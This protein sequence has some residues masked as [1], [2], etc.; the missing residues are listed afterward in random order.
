MRSQDK[1]LLS[2]RRDGGGG[3]AGYREPQGFRAAIC[4]G[5]Y[6]GRKT[7]INENLLEAWGEQLSES[8][9]LG[10]RLQK[11]RDTLP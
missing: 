11:Q 5:Q 3:K 6:W 2:D 9:D 10:T 8:E 4:T 7:N 1:L